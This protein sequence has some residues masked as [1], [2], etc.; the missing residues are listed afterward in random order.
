MTF[1]F[2]LV[3]VSRISKARSD[4]ILKKLLSF[5]GHPRTETSYE[6]KKYKS[7]SQTS[8]PLIQDCLE[9]FRRVE[10][11]EKDNSWYCNKCKDHVEATKQI[12]I[13]KVPPVLIFCLQRFKSHNIYFKDKLEDKVVFPLTGLDMRPYVLCHNDG[14]DQETD[15]IY[16]LYAVSNHYGSLAFGHYTAYAKN[17]DTGKWYDYNDSSVSELSEQY[18]ESEVVSNAAYVLYYIRRDFFPDKQIDF[19]Q[20]KILLEG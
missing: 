14:L 9:Q 3:F 11:L 15:P 17:P 1:Q 19:N 4:Y 5:D 8:N 20:I 2:E 6:S 16:D 7:A 10:K 18:P 13:Y 12:E